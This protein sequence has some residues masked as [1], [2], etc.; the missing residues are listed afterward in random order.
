MGYSVDRA[1]LRLE[2]IIL[3][4]SRSTYHK[5][6][7]SGQLHLFPWT[8]WKRLWNPSLY[9]SGLRDNSF[10]DVKCETTGRLHCRASSRAR[11]HNSHFWLRQDGWHGTHLWLHVIGER[12]FTGQGVPR[13]AWLVHLLIIFAVDQRPATNLSYNYHHIEF[14]FTNFLLAGEIEES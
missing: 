2:R 11:K 6:L 9:S 4:T 8:P 1:F 12:A 5:I 3:I 7:R 14:T 13:S 10:G